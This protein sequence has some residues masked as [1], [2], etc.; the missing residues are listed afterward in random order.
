MNTH[1]KAINFICALLVLILFYSK[2]ETKNA[3]VEFSSASD[4]K[5]R[6]LIVEETSDRTSSSA[7]VIYSTMWRDKIKSMGGEWIILDKDDNNLTQADWV[8]DYFSLHRQ[9]L[10]WVVYSNNGKIYS[11]KLPD[12]IDKF[13]NEINR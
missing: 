13:L 2:D 11:F 7:N 5:P 8:K 6:L 9:P 4:E 1:R 10:P 12:N 3:E